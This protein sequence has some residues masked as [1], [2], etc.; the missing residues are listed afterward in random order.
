M[1]RARMGAPQ[2]PRPRP[3]TLSASDQTLREPGP[4][5]LTEE[6]LL[7]LQILLKG[8]LL[9]DAHQDRLRACSQFAPHWRGGLGQARM[10]TTK[11]GRWMG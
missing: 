7:D 5:A 4:G 2:P 9:H 6:L 3:L 10:V 8:A 11:G 1:A